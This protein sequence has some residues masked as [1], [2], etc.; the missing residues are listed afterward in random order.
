ML[1][2]PADI[3]RVVHE[4]AAGTPITL[5]E[6]AVRAALHEAEHLVHDDVDVP[7]ALHFTFTRHRDVFSRDAARIL[8]KV[9]ED[10]CLRLGIKILANEAQLL[11]RLAEA[12]S[13]VQDA[14]DWFAEKVVMY[15]G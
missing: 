10:V 12:P 4:V 15:G 1:P 8:A 7:A 9:L 3:A 5:R 13:S 2:S 14:Q 6:S 11:A